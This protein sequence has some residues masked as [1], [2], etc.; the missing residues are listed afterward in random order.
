MIEGGW[1][2]FIWRP[3]GH[4]ARVDRRRLVQR[5]TDFDVL[6]QGYARCKRN[7]SVLAYRDMRQVNLLQHV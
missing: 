3:A 7:Q 6:R 2:V 1:F 4:L 5:Q